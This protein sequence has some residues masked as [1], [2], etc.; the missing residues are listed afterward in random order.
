M[1]NKLPITTHIL[2]LRDTEIL[3]LR[4]F[5]TGYEDGSYSVVAGHVDAGESVTQAAVRE[6]M[7]EAGVTVNL[8]NLEIV[9]IMNRK[10][11]DERVDFFMTVRQWTGEIVNAEPNKCDDLSWHPIANLPG[12]TIPYVRHAIECFQ[13]G[14]LYSEFGWDKSK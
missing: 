11:N 9:H 12:N 7:E 10:S 6:I 4:R 8:K 14:I 5:N 1:R 2:F 13:N 3:L